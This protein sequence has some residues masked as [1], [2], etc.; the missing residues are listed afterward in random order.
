MTKSKAEKALDE[1]KAEN[2]PNLE[3]NINLQ[4]PEIKE[5]LT[6][7]NPN[8]YLPNHI[9]IKAIKKS[10]KKLERSQRKLI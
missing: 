4:I 5:G 10:N 3:N 1:I 8:I 6:R 7:I 2:I 9:I